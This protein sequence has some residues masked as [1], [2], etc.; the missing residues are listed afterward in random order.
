MYPSWL[1]KKTPKSSNIRKIRALINDDSI[2]TVCESAK[3]PNIGECYSKD[4]VTFMI[5]GNVC[6]RNCRFCSVSKGTPSTLDPKEPE[7]IAKAAK[8]LRL[9]HVV[10]TSVTRDDLFDGGA[11]HFADTIHAVRNIHPETKVEVL[12]PDLQGHGQSISKIVE[13]E[14]NIINHNLET[15]PRL[16]EKIRPQADYKT[17]LK[18]LKSA[19]NLKNSLYTKS[20]IMVGLGEKREEVVRLMEDLRNVDCDIMTIGQYLRP[21]KDQVEVSEFISPDIFEGY[22]QTAERLG[23]KKVFSGPFVRSSYKA[24]EI[25]V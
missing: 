3:C 20:G 8:K 13:S 15:V 14:P 25:Y 19:K 22:K 21:S 9:K 6:T 17:S 24:S 1:I 2:R 4:T 18:V 11:G 12:I 23:F 7:N 16:Y 10:I 5:L